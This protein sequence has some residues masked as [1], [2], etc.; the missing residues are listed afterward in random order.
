[1][2]F[3]SSLLFFGGAAVASIQQL[4]SRHNSGSDQASGVVCPVLFEGRIPV[5]ATLQWFDT[6]SSVYDPNWTKGQNISW[7]S[8]LLF[9]NTTLAPFDE[10]NRHKPFEVTIDDRSIFKGRR[11]PPET[12]IRRA[13]LIM[14]GDKND[15]RA[16]AADN[17][18]VTYHWSV[19][20]NVEKPLN[21][22]HEYMNVWHERADFTGNQF[23]FVGGLVLPFNGGNGIDTKEEREKWRIQNS[24]KK[25]IFETPILFDQWQ[26][27]AVQVDHTKGTLKV[28]Y[29]AGAAPLQPVTEATPNNN[30]G[31]GQLQVGILKKPTDTT[32]IDL[33]GYQGPIPFQGEGQIYGGVFVETSTDGCVSTYSY[34]D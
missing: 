29:S 19:H 20:Q 4:G 24:D 14:P 26:N 1:M 25:F 30:T 28:F 3:Q 17:G 9:P 8:I 33:N 7:S 15:D 6:N 12:Y 21:F 5:D 11:S 18:T 34:S 13:G 22:S 23:T 31:L 32:N 16:D 10:P 2:R 27:F